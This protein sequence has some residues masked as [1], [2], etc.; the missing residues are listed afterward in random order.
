MGSSQH[1]NCELDQPGPSHTDLNSDS[2][3]FPA[4]PFCNHTDLYELFPNLSKSAVDMIYK[5]SSGKYTVAVNHLLDLSAEKIL[6]LIQQLKMTGPPIK[7]KIEEEDI[8]E[9]ALAFYKSISFDPS[10]PLRLSLANQP[11]LDTGG[12]RQQFFNDLFE[13]FAFKDP[14]SMFAGE[15]YRLRPHHS[16]ELLPLFKLLGTMITHSLI[17]DGPGFPYFAPYVYWYLV[18]NSEEMALTYVTDDD[19]SVPVREIT[20]QVHSYYM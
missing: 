10:R 17:Q 14:Y 7:L 2:E 9:D 20:S 3:E 1:E 4:V 16:P 15:Q 8:F 6:S 5:L 13:C 18:T 19:L 11:A 12:I